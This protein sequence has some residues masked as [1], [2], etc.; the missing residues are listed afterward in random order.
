MISRP[1][2]LTDLAHISGEQARECG[3]HV[4]FSSSKNGEGDVLMRETWQWSDLG[5]GAAMG[6]GRMKLRYEGH[7]SEMASG[8]KPAMA[9]GKGKPT[10]TPSRF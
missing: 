2:D 7:L 9:K 5:A 4:Q 8:V 10:V 3:G 1:Q 6:C